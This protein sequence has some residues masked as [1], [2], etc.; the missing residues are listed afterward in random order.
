[1]ERYTTYGTRT[2]RSSARGRAPNRQVTS[3][4]DARRYD[5]APPT[6]PTIAPAVL[7]P[8]PDARQAGLIGLGTTQSMEIKWNQTPASPAAHH[9]QIQLHQRARGEKHEK[10]IRNQ[11]ASHRH[12]RIP[13]SWFSVLGSAPAARPRSGR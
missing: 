7:Q 4:A 1:M 11:T 9:H 12:L 2:R 6:P 8:A 10:T 13:G 3:H 5:F